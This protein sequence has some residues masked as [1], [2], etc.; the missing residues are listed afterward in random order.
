MPLPLI[1]K[2]AEKKL[3]VVRRENAGRKIHINQ[4]TVFSFPVFSRL[5]VPIHGLSGNTKKFFGQDLLSRVNPHFKLNES[6]LALTCL[7]QA[8]CKNQGALKIFLQRA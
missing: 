7:G 2:R 1:Q 8:I 3:V 5:M 6:D 4:P